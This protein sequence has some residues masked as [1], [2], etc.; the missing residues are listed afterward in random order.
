MTTMESVEKLS[1]DLRKAAA[2]LSD[3]EARFLV[4]SYYI[5]QEARKRADNQIRSI[6]A[7]EPHEILTWFGA[8]SDVL[9]RNIRAALDKY[10]DSKEIGRRMKSIYGIGPV[11]S[12]GLLA[13]L[14]IHQ[15]KAAGVFWRFAGLDPSDTWGEGEKRP[16]NA[17]LK[18]LCWHIG[19]CFLKFH[20]VDKCYYGKIY[21]ERKNYEKR[22]NDRGDNAETAKALLPRYKKPT[23]TRTHLLSG[24]LPPAQ[25]D[26]RA[27]R[28]AVKIFLSH[29]HAVWFKLEYGKDAPQPFPITHLG[30]IEEIK[31]PAE[32]WVSQEP[33]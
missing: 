29:L 15:A 1:R 5:M 10:S 31:P 24:K 19:Q 26:A 16:W 6:G 32:W 23:E 17:S 21:E 18:T 22:R 25:I 13:H 8:Q 2:T 9:E 28:Y 14:D 7:E 3:R 27:R 11:I 33:K 20:N 4:D 12:A 30:H